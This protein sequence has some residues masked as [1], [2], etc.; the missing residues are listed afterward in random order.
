M[1]DKCTKMQKKSPPS[2][3]F[4]CQTAP[5][6][7]RNAMPIL[8]VL[9][10]LLPEKCSVLEIGSGTGQHSVIFSEGIN[11]L[12]WIPSD[13]DASNFES[14]TEWAQ[15]AANNILS[16]P[17]LIDASQPDWCLT[18]QDNIDVIVSINV[19]HI[20]PWSV[21]KGILKG[22]QKF[23]PKGGFLYFYGPFIQN[24]VPTAAGNIA[25][26]NSLR[27]RHEDWGLRNLNEV[28]KLANKH[29]LKLDRIVKMPSNNLSVIFTKT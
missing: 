13:I 25:F 19:I 18:S 8:K 2:E 21:T 5:A 12:K 26:D 4:L 10:E 27:E 28:E 23:L 1:R 6:A 29:A 22:A 11:C 17:R 3:K 15:T 24:N 14:I 20:S 16:S 7:A 9:K